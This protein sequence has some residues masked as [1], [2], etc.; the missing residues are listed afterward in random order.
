MKLTILY[1][2]EVLDPRLKADWGFAALVETH[3]RRILFDTGAK[4]GLLLENMKQLD[5]SVQEIDEVFI[6]H[7]HWDHTGGLAAVLEQKPMPVYV[8]DVLRTPV[9]GDHLI[10][11]E[12]LKQIHDHIYSTGTLMRIEQSLCVE[13]QGKVIVVA[14]CSHPGVGAILNAASRIGPVAAIIGGLHGFDDFSLLASVETVCATHCTQ[15]KDEIRSRFPEAVTAGGA[16]RI[17]EL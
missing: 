8:P 7:D 15:H 14:G 16:G 10:A 13:Q 17:I 1:D 4:P 2:N 3:A 9:T 12:N 11:V 6:S 5:I